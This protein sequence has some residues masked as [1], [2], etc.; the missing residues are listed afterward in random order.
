V[1]QGNGNY[2]TDVAVIGGGVAGL[3]AATYLAKG[4]RDV[5]VYER[6]RTVGGRA[7]SQEHDGFLFNQGPHALLSKEVLQELGISLTG[8]SPPILKTLVLKNGTLHK[9]PLG[10]TGFFN[11]SLMTMSERL[12]LIALFLK[13]FRGEPAAVAHE[14]VLSWIERHTEA[15]PVREMLLS[16]MRTSTYANDPAQLSMDVF[17]R[18]IQMATGITYLDGGWQAL[19]D[20]LETAA[21]DVGVKIRTG[22]RIDGI[23]FE[24]ERPALRL[25]DGRSVATSAVV[26]TVNPPTAHKMLPESRVLQAVARNAR[27]IRMATL[28]VALRTLPEPSQ[29]VVL[30][31]DRP[32]Y[33]SVHSAAA[34]L[35]PPNGA[36]IHVVSY[37]APDA[38]G[39]EAEAP[40]E[41]LLDLAQPGWRDEV[42]H[43]RFLPELIVNNYM[44][45]PPDGLAGRPDP[46]LADLPHVYLA[47]DWVGSEG[48][49]T[50]ASFASARRAARL[51]LQQSPA[52]IHSRSTLEM[53]P[54][55]KV[56]I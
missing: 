49:L 24:G 34:D 29:P 40:L 38:V 52:R 42:V 32:Y 35:G 8:G 51:L 2:G 41:Q 28:D 3:T 43:R 39:A 20:A 27:Q 15:A 36:L 33:L 30:G 23:T 46:A 1:K 48:W 4:G 5:T 45:T 11:S 25:A 55:Q 12:R 54:L 37:L 9:F 6:S 44:P 17:M 16:L 18:Q 22:S 26:V 14:T 7:R 21:R 13:L 19:V 47:G 10:P 53:E 56:V 50:D 31:L